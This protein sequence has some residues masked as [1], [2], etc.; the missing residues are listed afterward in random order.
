MLLP[1]L[2][3]CRF[4]GLQSSKCDLNMDAADMLI[5]K[6]FIWEKRQSKHAKTLQNL[7]AE[8]EEHKKNVNI[9]QV[10]GSAGSVAGAAA[11]AG[12]GVAAIFTGGLAIP[13]IA[14]VGAVVSGLGFATS[15]GSEVTNIIISSHYMKKA[16]K[17]EEKI[18][19]LEMGIHKLVEL[20]KV[21]GKRRQ[22]ASFCKDIPPEDDVVEQILRAMAKRYGLEL[23]EGVSL[24]RVMS[25]FSKHVN[26]QGDVAFNIA[27]KSA[28]GLGLLFKFIIQ[29]AA[30]LS[31][32]T[33][34]SKL[35]PQLVA[36]MGPKAA[37]KALGRVSL[38]K[39]Y[40]FQSITSYPINYLFLPFSDRRW[41]S[42][43][44]VFSS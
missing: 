31:G 12:A 5:D 43:T 3:I 29:A 14:V 2:F 26:S 36:S 8:L 25:S 38:D 30:K 24:L 9:S 22:Q 13:V 23:H 35:L 37:A 1:I 10:A 16:K 34:M 33:V 18:E 4:A 11:M 28:L 42:W 19:K 6:I 32:K 21:E 40:W 41:S 15:M 44:C 27:K 39:S 7:A 17:E 20:L